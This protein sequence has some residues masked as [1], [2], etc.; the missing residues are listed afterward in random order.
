[1]PR[2]KEAVSHG[3]HPTDAPAGERMDF[4][5]LVTAIRQVHEHCAAQVKRAVNVSLTLRNWVIGGY[6]HH[7]EL[8]GRDRATYGEGLFAALAERL[9][10]VNIPN[11]NRS[12]LYRYR[13]FFKTYPQIVATLSP[14]FRNLLGIEGIQQ[15]AQKVATVTP[16]SG[17]QIVERLS[18]SHIELLLEIDDPLKR[19]F[20]EVECI[21]GNWSVRALKRQIATLY[22]ERSGLSADKEKLA[23]MAHAA[24]EAAEPALAIRDPYVFEFLGL[25]ARDAVAETD[26]EAALVENL[27]DFLLELG[28]GFC[29]EAQQKSI[30]IGHT[31]GF[32]DLVFYHRLLKCHVLIDLKVDEFRHEHIGQLNTY[33]TWYRHHMMAEDDN[34][35][36]GLLLCTQKDHAL[37][38]YA[39]AAIDNQLFVSKYQLELP[40]KEELQRFLEDKRRELGD[41][42]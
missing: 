24:A 42:L 41:D 40:T 12:R 27:R 15:D 23:A 32:V 25:R 20:Y 5:T 9:Q 6:I 8:H 1:M 29:L 39:L 36:V 21:R 19:A 13:D 22:F 16:L 2:K 10:A 34:P 17:Q 4:A 14:Q 33:V 26:M 11:C 35:P 31:R 7:Y 37:V 38:E 3:E 30:V 28:Y 18:Y